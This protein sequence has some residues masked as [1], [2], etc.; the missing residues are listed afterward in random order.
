VVGL[1]SKPGVEDKLNILSEDGQYDLA[2]AC[3]TS[4]SG[5]RKRGSDGKWIYPVTLPNGGQ[6]ILF[7][8]LM[9]NVCSN[10]C[11]YCPL[12]ANQDVRRCSLSIEETANTFLDYLNNGDVFGLFLSS[13]VIGTPDRTME[14]LC[15][16]AEVLRYQHKFKGYIHLKII[17]GSSDAAVQR[18]VSLATA[19]SVNIEVPGAEN[20]RKLSDSKDFEN[21]IIRPMKL[22]NQLNLEKRFGHSV[23][24]TT[25]F[26][27]GAAGESDKDIVRYTAALYDRLRLNRV[28]YSA[29]QKGL[30]ERNLPGEQGGD[31]LAGTG[32]VREHRLYQVDFLLR[33]YGFKAE[34]INYGADGLLLLEKDPKQIW[35][36]LHPEFFPVNVNAADK[37]GLLKIPG[38][39]PGAA[40]KILRTRKDFR[41]TD[42]RS[43]LGRG[44][45]AEK[46]LKYVVY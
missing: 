1:F 33:K 2:C 6:S 15:G 11:K 3:A 38:I 28:Y 30:G 17:P 27:V 13:G 16:V 24:Q 42:L 45:L 14:K 5:H 4:Q 10:D 39:G 25:Q 29:Y 44:K 18:A 37:D 34:D 40:I 7:K 21:D 32:F 46:A 19:V 36:D 43:V 9:S 22:I 26:I 41:I 23:K 31:I 8:T 20:L 35:A 12:R